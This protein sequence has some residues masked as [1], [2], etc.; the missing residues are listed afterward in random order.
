MIFSIE[1]FYGDLGGSNWES[2]WLPL[3]ILAVLTSFIIYNILLMFGRA[4]HIRELET[5]AKA[6]MLQSAATAFM[7]IFLVVMVSSAMQLAAT[8]IAGEIVCGEDVIRIGQI[9][10]G[11]TD[12]ERTEQAHANMDL[13]FDAIRCRLQQ[14]AQDIADIQSSLAGIPVWNEFNAMN[15]GLSSFGITFFKGDWVSDLY[16][17][18]ETKRITNN[19]ATVLLIGLNAQ[20]AILM[21]I[22]ANMLH[23]FIPLGILLRSFYFTRG[24]GAL[25]ISVGIGMYFIFPVFFVLLDPGFTAAPPPPPTVTQETPAFCYATMSNT[26]TMLQTIEAEGTGSTGDLAMASLGEDLSKSY[27][28]LILHPLVCLF[29]TMVFIRYIMS[30][31]GGDTYELTKMITKVV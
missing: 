25:F 2:M 20:S 7:A 23:V 5:F 24:V 14:R 8:Y 15:I 9:D 6:E 29:L 16:E 19:L 27:I 3:C 12:I 1:S 22:Q 17:S 30:V 4:F 31:M 18:T 28:S 13:A 11:A 21:Y 26:L 10:P